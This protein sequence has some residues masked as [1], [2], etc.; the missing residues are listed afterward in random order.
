MLADDIDWLFHQVQVGEKVKVI[1]EPVKVS[2]EPDRTVF[3]EA[4]EPLTRSDGS[5]KRLVIPQTLKW[6]LEEHQLSDAMAKA[7]VI[8]QNGIPK[9]IA[10]D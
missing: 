6:W 8:S 10:Q 7:V 3:I 1:D 5:K 4:H 9:Q 2:L